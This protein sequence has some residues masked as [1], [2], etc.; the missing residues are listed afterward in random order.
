MWTLSVRN[1]PFGIVPV[2]DP[3]NRTFGLREDLERTCDTDD[4]RGKVPEF[5]RDLFTR[6][7]NR[8][9]YYS[10]IREGSHPPV[11]ER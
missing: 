3:T 1:A 2:S 10:R 7:P 11:A 9:I 6:R 5:G 4:G 8:A